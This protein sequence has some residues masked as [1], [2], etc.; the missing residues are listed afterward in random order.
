M[1]PTLRNISAT[2]W[3]PEPDTL[4]TLTEIY[5]AAI[6][7]L[8]LFPSPSKENHICIAKCNQYHL[9]YTC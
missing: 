3:V 9:S 8:L 2:S 6:S 1:T 4:I 7:A 5:H